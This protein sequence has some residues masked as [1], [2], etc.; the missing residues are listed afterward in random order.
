MRKT[1]SNKA[2]ALALV[3]RRQHSKE[4]PNEDHLQVACVKAFS[5]RYPERRG[6]LFATFQNP[7]DI[8]QTNIWIA[9]GLIPGVSDLIYIDHQFR[10][11]AIELKQIGKRHSS[12]H[13][14]RQCNWMLANAYRSGFCTSVDMFFDMVEEKSDGISCKFI[15]SQLEKLS[16]KSYCF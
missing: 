12:D 5:E 16:T 13:L 15:L 8:T 11:V 7:S 2:E 14:I 1:P 6:R 9:M 10:I 3:A 4:N